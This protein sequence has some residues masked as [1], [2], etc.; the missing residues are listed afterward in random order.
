MSVINKILG[1]LK[2]KDGA[3]ALSPKVAVRMDDAMKKRV[4]GAVLGMVALVAASA[5]GWMWWSARQKAAVPQKVAQ[6]PAKPIA[7]PQPHVA[8]EPVAA[9]GVEMAHEAA[10]S[11]FLLERALAMPVRTIA[12]PFGDTDGVVQRVVDACGYRFGIATREE[13]AR[14]TDDLLA[15]PRIP[16]GGLD[17]FRT[18][19]ES[20]QG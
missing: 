18:L 2:K 3:N 6:A 12:Y 5:G 13:T 14:P 4:M 20:V 7:A 17:D 11:R 8:A 1:N 10:H 9:S 15:L 16:V 19:L